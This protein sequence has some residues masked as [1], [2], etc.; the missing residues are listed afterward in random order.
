MNIKGVEEHE[1]SKYIRTIRSAIRELKPDQGRETSI[2]VYSVLEA[3]GVTC[4]ARQHAIKKLL[5]AGI[6]GKGTE[7]EDLVGALSAVNRAIELEVIRGEDSKKE[8]KNN[9][10]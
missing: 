2:D 5:C 1:G 7:L 6:R 9:G 3:F 4:P 10:N 8:N